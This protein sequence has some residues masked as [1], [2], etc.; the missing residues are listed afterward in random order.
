MSPSAADAAPL[1]GAHLRLFP[2]DAARTL[3][4]APPRDAAAVLAPEPPEP[5]AQWY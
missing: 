4:Q 1:V 5:V 2:A 3:D